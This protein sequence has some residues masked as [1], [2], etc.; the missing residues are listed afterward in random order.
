MNNNLNQLMLYLE[1]RY[2]TLVIKDEEILINHQL[3]DPP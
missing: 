1:F 3:Y 2:G